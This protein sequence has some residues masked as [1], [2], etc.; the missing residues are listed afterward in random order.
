M[1]TTGVPTSRSAGLDPPEMDEQVAELLLRVGDDDAQAVGA[2]DHAG[3]A[4]LAAAFAVE[5]RLVQ[6]DGDVGAGWRRF[7]RR[8]VTTRA[9]ISPSALSV[10]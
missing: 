2:G 10:A 6:H 7:G 3:I 5:R 9:R 1:A 4:D 8:A